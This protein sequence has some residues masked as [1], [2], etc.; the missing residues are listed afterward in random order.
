M[1]KERKSFAFE[2]TL[3]GRSYARLIPQWREQGYVVT[4]VFVRLRDVEM[5]RCRFIVSPNECVAVATIF[6]RKCP[7]PFPVGPCQL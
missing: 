5:S 4:L 7:P 1:W 6:P 2:T 3:S